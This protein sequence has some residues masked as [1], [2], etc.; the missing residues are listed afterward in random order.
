MLWHL[1]HSIWWLTKVICTPDLW[2]EQAKIMCCSEPITWAALCAM[3]HIGWSVWKLVQIEF[4]RLFSISNVTTGQF[5]PWQA[6]NS[7]LHTFITHHQ[8]TIGVLSCLSS[9]YLINGWKKFNQTCRD[10]YLQCAHNGLTFGVNL[11]QDRCHNQLTFKKTRYAIVYSVYQTLNKKN[12]HSCSWE[13]LM[14]H[15]SS[16]THCKG[17]VLKT[18]FVTVWVTPVRKNK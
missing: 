7:K 6:N 17:C 5:W 1:P 4:Q 18:L 11:I 15:T 2:G 14:A 10:K 13:L 3:A 8:T 12:W 16:A 9:N